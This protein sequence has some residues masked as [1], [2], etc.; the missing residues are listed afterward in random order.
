M[1]RL[2]HGAREL[3]RMAEWSRI[4]SVIDALV[5]EAIRTNRQDTELLAEAQER[6]EKTL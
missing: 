4:A 1:E 6:I 3:P 2:H 5:L